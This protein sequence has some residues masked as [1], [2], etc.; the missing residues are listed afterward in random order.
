MGTSRRTNHRRWSP[1]RP[2]AV[3][4]SLQA[5]CCPPSR[6]EWTFLVL[7]APPPILPGK[8]PIRRTPPCSRRWHMLSNVESYKVVVPK[9]VLD[10]TTADKV[11]NADCAS[12]S[13]TIA[14]SISCLMEKR[15]DAEA[16]SKEN[17]RNSNKDESQ[18][19]NTILS[20]TN[21]LFDRLLYSLSGASGKAAPSDSGKNQ[22]AP[23]QVPRRP[24]RLRRR[25]RRACCRPSWQGGS[26]RVLHNFWIELFWRTPRPAFNGGAVASYILFNPSDSTVAQART[27][28]FAYNYS[29]FG[30][31]KMTQPDNFLP[32]KKDNTESQPF[33]RWTLVPI[34]T[35]RRT[36]SESRCDW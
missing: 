8:S 28:R 10:P 17:I 1:P 30:S 32:N 29:K 22:L 4:G 25:Q 16:K 11:D 15:K 7:C 24:L 14:G 36:S 33:G 19:T 2:R 27:L 13:N 5:T 18:L 9:L 26:Y 6:W 34:S 35:H 23:I 20:K 12:T 21:T 3:W 31:K